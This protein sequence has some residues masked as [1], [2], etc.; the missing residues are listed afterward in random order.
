VRASAT[1]WSRTFGSLKSRSCVDRGPVRSIF[2]CVDVIMAPAYGLGRRKR[3]GFK[4]SHVKAYA[5]ACPHR[6][7]YAP[8]HSSFNVPSHETPVPVEG[9]MYPPSHT[10]RKKPNMSEIVRFEDPPMLH[11]GKHRGKS[12]AEV[13]ATDPKWVQYML[14]QPGFQ[15]KNPTLVQFFVNGSVAGLGGSDIEPAETP[16]HNALQAKFTQDAYCLAAVAMFSAGQKISTAA[17]VHADSKI[18]VGIAL[19]E[20]LLSFHPA[21]A[22]RSFE[23]N[24][25]DVQFD[26]T[27]AHS[28]LDTSH[29]PVCSCTSLPLPNFPEGKEYHPDHRDD[30][31]IYETR[32]RI[33]KNRLKPKLRDG[34][35]SPHDGESRFAAFTRATEHEVA[36]IRSSMTYFNVW[37]GSLD[38]EIV[39][40]KSLR[41]GLELK[42]SIGDDFPAVLRQVHRYKSQRAGQHNDRTAV[43]VGEFRSASV[44]WHLVKKQ[45]WES[46]V[47]LV[48]EAELDA[49]VEQ[50]AQ[51]WGIDRS[52]PEADFTVS[53]TDQL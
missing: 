10:Q 38:S 42:P 25:W 11:F 37:S 5:G 7:S 49:L 21:I 53:F 40:R 35:A 24:A 39:H 48:K 13:M 44:P 15:E 29:E 33:N 26:F 6:G 46:G 18:Q 36:C 16:E 8:Q 20:R 27:S 22:D 28:E 1:I 34:D 3:L 47:L 41:F 43:V 31:L 4:A 45:F 12:A 51:E 9:F 23:E 30:R 19:T 52:A 2:P 32:V 17:E 50:H 14:A